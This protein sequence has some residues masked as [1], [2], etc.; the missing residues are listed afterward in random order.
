VEARRLDRG[1]GLVGEE[2]E[3][4]RVGRVKSSTRPSRDSLSATARTPRRRP[5]TEIATARHFCRSSARPPSARSASLLISPP[6]GSDHAL[7]VARAKTSPADAALEQHGAR[8]STRTSVP[9]PAS[10]SEIERKSTSSASAER[11]SCP[12]SERPR[13]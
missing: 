13:S 9:L 1:R 11:S 5:G 3:Q 12:P 2:R 7:H 8:G 4:P 6:S 10:V